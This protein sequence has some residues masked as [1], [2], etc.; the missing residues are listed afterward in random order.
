ML[1]QKSVLSIPKNSKQY[2][3]ICENDSPVED[4]K[5]SL[6]EML[7]FVQTIIDNAAKAPVVEEQTTEVPISE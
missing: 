6:L 4:V 3:F 1:S 7:G 5:S 2:L